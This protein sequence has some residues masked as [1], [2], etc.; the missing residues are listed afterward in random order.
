GPAARQLVREGGEGQVDVVGGERGAV[1]PVDA[2]AVP[3][4]GRRDRLDRLDGVT[5]VGHAD[6]PE[7]YVRRDAL[8][9]DPQAGRVAEAAVRGGRG[10]SG[11]RARGRT[12]G[13]GGCGTTSTRCPGP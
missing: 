8:E 7:P 12:G 4:P 9:P 13:G 2:F 10:G 5:R 1:E 6:V 3:L 11:G